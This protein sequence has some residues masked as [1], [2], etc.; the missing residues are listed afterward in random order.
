MKTASFRDRVARWCTRAAEAGYDMA[1]RR[2]WINPTQH[3]SQHVTIMRVDREEFTV[4]PITVVMEWCGP[5]DDRPLMDYAFDR[6]RAMMVEKLR[7]RII[8]DVIRADCDFTRH[9]VI[10]RINLAV[11]K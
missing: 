9:K 8:L 6:A 5:W 11:R 4:E 3:P 1:V 10:G 7:D 2:G